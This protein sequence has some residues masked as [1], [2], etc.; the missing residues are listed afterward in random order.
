MRRGPALTTVVAVAAMLSIALA[1]CSDG[2]S[3]DGGDTGD[4]SATGDLV[5]GS[6]TR[7]RLPG[8]SAGAAQSV[9]AP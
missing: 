2:G 3:D 7:P 5:P 6:T 8:V 4:G 9:K 1:A